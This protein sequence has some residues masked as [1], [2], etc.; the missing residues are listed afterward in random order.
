MRYRI[1]ELAGLARRLAA[2]ADFRHSI[3]EFL[4][5]VQLAVAARPDDLE[6]MISAEPELLGE[7]RHD[8]FLACLAE[9]IAMT[10]RLVTPGWVGGT[11]RFLAEWWFPANVSGYE[12]IAVR[13]SPPAFRRR[14]IFI[15][16]SMLERV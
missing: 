9:H 10:H 4:D 8:A 12:A 5:D 15:P 6:H 1:G 7:P 3:R 13:E 2:G 16:V 14:G 11:D